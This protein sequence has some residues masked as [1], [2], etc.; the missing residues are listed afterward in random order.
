[1]SNCELCKKEV[2]ERQLTEQC[3]HYL[4]LSCDGREHDDEIEN[5]RHYCSMISTFEETKGKHGWPN[6][7]NINCEELK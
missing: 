4:C 6:F 1:M 3:G 5:A 7:K 2:D